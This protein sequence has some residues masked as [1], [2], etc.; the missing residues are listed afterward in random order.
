[1]LGLVPN[2]G[3]NHAQRRFAYQ[4][5]LYFF[6]TIASTTGLYLRNSCPPHSCVG[7][8]IRFEPSQPIKTSTRLET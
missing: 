8:A 3:F 6:E 7:S 5:S 2:Q 4:V 1:M